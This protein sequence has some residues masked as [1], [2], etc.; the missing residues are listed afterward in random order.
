MS[1]QNKL[2]R[3]WGFDL[4][5]PLALPG[6]EYTKK[7]DTATGHPFNLPGYTLSDTKV[8]VFENVHKS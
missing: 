6:L 4:F 1:C 2:G 3:G 7:A 8:T 5:N